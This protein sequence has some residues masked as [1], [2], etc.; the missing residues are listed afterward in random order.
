MIVGPIPCPKCGK[1]SV[2]PRV[3]AEERLK[4]GK[5]GGEIHAAQLIYDI[6]CPN[7]GPVMYVL[8]VDHKPN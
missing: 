6:D 4:S 7:C 5:A 1:G 8:P 2:I 3:R